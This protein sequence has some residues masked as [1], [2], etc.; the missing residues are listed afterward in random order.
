MADE[1]STARLRFRHVIGPG[2]DVISREVSGH[3]QVASTSGAPT[4]GAL[5]VG[6]GALD[7]A[8]RR[9]LLRLMSAD[10][11][12]VGRCPEIMLRI[13][14]GHPDEH[15]RWSGSGLLTMRGLTDGVRLVAPITPSGRAG[16]TCRL[17][18]GARIDRR[19]FALTAGR[20]RVGRR[21]E[22]VADLAQRRIGL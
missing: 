10:F 13:C 11:L 17:R 7:C 9:A 16:D 21:I 18:L 6:L 22:V 20:W 15:G 5:W 1:G 19:D 3:V 2:I 12:D 8:H 14:D 4:D